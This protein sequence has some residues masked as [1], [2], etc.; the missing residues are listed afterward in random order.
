MFFI[1][2]AVPRDVSSDMAKLDGSSAVAAWNPPLAVAAAS[3]NHAATL[4]PSAVLTAP[5]KRAS[6]AAHTTASVARSA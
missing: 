4:G 5:K 1:D 3:A 2:I 6:H